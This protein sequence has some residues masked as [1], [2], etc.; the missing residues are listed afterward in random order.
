MLAGETPFKGESAIAVAMQHLQ[1]VPIDLAKRRSD[2]PPELCEIVHR[3]LEKDPEKRYS[4]AQK[5]LN[6]L[7]K[8]V[9]SMRE[10]GDADSIEMRI[11]ET[12]EKAP[13]LPVRRPW[14]VLSLMA[15]LA[16]GASAALGWWQRPPIPVSQGAAVRKEA[17]AKDQFHAALMR[18]DNEDAFAAVKKYFPTE[19]V[20]VQMA[21]EQL[22]LL[23][24]KDA[25]N[26]ARK[27][28]IENQISALRAHA[29]N[30]FT[31]EAAIAEAYALFQTNQPQLA[32]QRLEA[33]GLLALTPDPAIKGSWRTMLQQITDPQQ[34][35]RPGPGGNPNGRPPGGPQGGPRGPQSPFESPREPPPGDNPPP[36]NGDGPPAK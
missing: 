32:R 5:V 14:L 28:A 6:D 16:A 29:T 1:A 20:W 10:T 25:K 27:K 33:N 9:R 22:M 12:P 18:V 7:K 35:F 19:T 4:S 24:L 2:L 17:T 11:F 15:I 13:S 26:P 21:D 3:M 31:M 34:S 23:Y 36:P 8:V 30:R